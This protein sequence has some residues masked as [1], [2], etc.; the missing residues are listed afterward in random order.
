M[1]IPEICFKTD[2]VFHR[3]DECHPVLKS[4]AAEMYQWTVQNNCP[5]MITESKTTEAEDRILHRVSKTHS[6]G[7]AFDVSYHNWNKENADKFIAY[8][9]HKYAGIAA[10]TMSGPTL[11]VFH[12]AG[13]GNHFHVQIRPGLSEANISKV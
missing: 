9:S 12:D 4:L 7:R 5:F 8:F 6:E 3:F 11:I 1:K 2:L 13:S 10:V